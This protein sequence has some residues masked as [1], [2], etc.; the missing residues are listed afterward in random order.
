MQDC[1]G[2]IELKLVKWQQSSRGV[3]IYFDILQN[4]QMLKEHVHGMTPRSVNQRRATTERKVQ[5]KKGLLVNAG[6][7]RHLLTKNGWKTTVT[8]QLVTGPGATQQM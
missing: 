6:I 5:P 4:V 2:R 7:L 8:H 1:T 3:Y